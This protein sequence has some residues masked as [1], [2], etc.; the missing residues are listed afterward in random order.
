MNFFTINVQRCEIHAEV[1][2]KEVF[3]YNV[4]GM[5]YNSTDPTPGLADWARVYLF[6]PSSS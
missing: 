5:D 2:F 6:D 4:Y 3:Y 1:D